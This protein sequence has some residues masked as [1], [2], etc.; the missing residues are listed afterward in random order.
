[1]GI[2]GK[3]IYTPFASIIRVLCDDYGLAKMLQY[4]QDF[5]GLF[6]ILV[7]KIK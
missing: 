7:Q 6:V 5:F 4:L 2:E 1:M 3:S